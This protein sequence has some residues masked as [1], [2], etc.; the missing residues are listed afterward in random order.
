[1]NFGSLT[2][3]YGFASRMRC[4]CASFSAVFQ[5]F[6]SS[7]IAKSPAVA[8][9]TTWSL[10]GARIFT[11]GVGAGGGGLASPGAS[12]TGGGG[13]AAGAGAALAEAGAGAAAAIAGAGGGGGGGGGRLSFPP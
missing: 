1:G 5:F 3:M 2:R 7:L 10:V 9:G 11:D 8:A 6:T 12:G 13:G 4:T